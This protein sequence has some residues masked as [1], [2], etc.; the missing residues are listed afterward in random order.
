[1]AFAMRASCL[2]TAVVIKA[3]E[4]SGCFTE[5][6]WTDPQAMEQAGKI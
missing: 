1:M 5:V 3:D 6:R 4:K 2:Q